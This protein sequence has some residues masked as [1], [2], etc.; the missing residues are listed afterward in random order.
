[1]ET[2]TKKSASAKRSNNPKPPLK[3]RRNGV[4]D[5]MKQQKYLYLMSLPFVAWVFVFNYLPLWGWTMAFQNYKPARSFGQQEWVGFK[6]F[7]ELFSDDRFYLVLRNTLAMSLMGLIVGFV[8]PIIFAILLN[9]MKGMFFKRAVQT[10]SYLPH[11]VSWVVVAGIITKMLSTDGGIIN[12]LLIGLNI[13]DQPIQ[14]MAKGNLF[15]YIVTAS[16]M[17]K[18][19]GWNAIIYLAAI[20]GID[21]ELYEASRVDGANRFRQ[22][23]HITLP[24]IRTTISVLFIMS[25]GHLISIGFEKQ[26]LLQNSL[27]LDYSEVL[28]LYAL[29]YGL[30]MGRFSYG[31]AIGIFNSVVSIILL[32]TANGLFKKFTKESIM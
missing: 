2:L 29:N 23:W 12:D 5:R 24:G 19:T 28:D 4:W 1:M 22:M 18:E 13:I 27:V 26:F 15:W 3:Q 7:V 30:N 25:I 9:E 8:V 6:H 32:F 17:W 20:T 14:F 21:Q 16:D 31:T 11:F 10:V